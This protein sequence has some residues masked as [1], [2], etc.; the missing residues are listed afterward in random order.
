[1]A[2]ALKEAEAGK[3]ANS[4]AQLFEVDHV[5]GGAKNSVDDGEYWAKA[6]LGWCQT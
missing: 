3:L 1:V 2:A 6:C 5:F 4:Q